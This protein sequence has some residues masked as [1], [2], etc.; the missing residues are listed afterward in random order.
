MTILNQRKDTLVNY[1][2][3]D[4][5][6]LVSQYIQADIGTKTITLASYGSAERAAEVFDD[7]VMQMETVAHTSMF[8]NIPIAVE[9]TELY[10][11]PEM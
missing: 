8:N 4:L 6:R 10:E 7:L 3:V 9:H 11:M 5:V 1:D 2:M